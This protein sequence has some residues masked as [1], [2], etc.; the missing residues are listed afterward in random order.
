LTIKSAQ[1]TSR[2]AP[3]DEFQVTSQQAVHSSLVT[4]HCP[5]PFCR[6]AFAYTCPLYPHRTG[7]HM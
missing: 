5:L 7:E 6:S 1:H 4:L 2:T 3:S